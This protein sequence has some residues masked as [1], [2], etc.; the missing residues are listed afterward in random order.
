[1]TYQKV[2]WDVYLFADDTKI[3]KVLNSE[4][5]KYILQSG[6]TNLMDWS[7]KRFLGFHTNKCKHIHITRERDNPIDQIYYLIQGKDLELI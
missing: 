2:R 7:A 3:F 4:N 5:D 6:L 1:M